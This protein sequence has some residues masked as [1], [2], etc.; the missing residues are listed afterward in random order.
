MYCQFNTPHPSATPLDWSSEDWDGKKAKAREQC[1]ILDFNILEK[2]KQKML[3]DRAQDIPQD[4]MQDNQELDLINGVQG[5]SL[6]PKTDIQNL[7][8]VPVPPP[9]VPQVKDKGFR[10]RR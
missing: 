9:D 8:D 2:Q 4:M 5:L 1:P 10:L 6:D 7:M 3:Q